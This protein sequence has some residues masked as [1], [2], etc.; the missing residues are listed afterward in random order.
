MKRT[1]LLAFFVTAAAHG[2]Q[3]QEDASVAAERARLKAEREKVEAA[4]KVEEKR[5][6]REFAVNDC[7]DTARA[8]RRASVD[9]LRRQEIALNDVERK[10]KAAE[11]RSAIEEKEG[12]Q[13]QR[14]ENA[15]PKA[16]PEP[17]RALRAN[18]RA[19]SRASQ[20]ASAPRMAAVLVWVVWLCVAEIADSKK[21]RDA[22]AARNAREHEERL[23]QAK[24]HEEA[25]KK[26]LAGQKKPPASSLKDPG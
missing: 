14:E 22:E 26:K 3:P 15:Q 4:Y 10:R 18:E 17:N 12:T 16:P 8:K 24:E 6:Y 13:R 11:R 2:Q 19:A 20:A 5:C 1:L 9:D 7:L 25:L 23:L 21:R